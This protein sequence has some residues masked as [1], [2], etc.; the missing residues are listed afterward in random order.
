M[1]KNKILILSG[2]KNDLENT[3]KS[4]VNIAKVI[5]AELEF[6]Y[7]KKPTEIVKSE[8]QLSA[9]RT[10]NR[11]QIHLQK[12][13]NNLLKPYE[14]KH[15]VEIKKKFS[16]GNVKIEIENH[17]N[18]LKPDIIVLGKRKAN[19]LN[20]TGDR[21]TDF[22]L[23]RFS[24]PILIANKNNLFQSMENLNIGAL[25]F[26]NN[27]NSNPF[28]DKLVQQSQKPLKSFKVIEKDNNTPKAIKTESNIVEF[29]FEKN[30]NSI[31][32]LSNYLIKSKIDLLCLNRN[33]DNSNE[34]NSTK[35]LSLRDIINKVNVSILISN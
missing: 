24:I 31:S 19:L 30:D 6:F 32:N 26:N 17:I 29:V 9:I 2:L 13:L 34:T 11:K 22:I 4:A 16:F 7:V 18:N 3:I 33:I 12:E 1:K 14:I 8:S 5:D 27:L 25:N 28:M 15:N 35:A 23:S 20:I 21:I 10:I